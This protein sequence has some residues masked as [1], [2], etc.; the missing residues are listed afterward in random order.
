MGL[1]ALFI[2]WQLILTEAVNQSTKSEK[3]TRSLEYLLWTL[4]PSDWTCSGLSHGLDVKAM[5]SKWDSGERGPVYPQWCWSSPKWRILHAQMHERD[6][7][8]LPGCA[9]SVCWWLEHAA[10]SSSSC[11]WKSFLEPLLL[12]KSNTIFNQF[13]VSWSGLGGGM[14][15]LH[16][17]FQPL[18]KMHPITPVL[19]LGLFL[20]YNQVLRQS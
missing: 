5:E 18:P 8:W 20:G 10:S 7:D 13:R 11:P 9:C 4:V 19:L 1:S 3:S 17:C 12:S 15:T 2:L 14:Q 16:T 6:R